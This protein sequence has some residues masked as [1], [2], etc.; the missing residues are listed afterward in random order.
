[1]KN[2]FVCSSCGNEFPKW[3][4]KCPACGEWN[5]LVETA[6]KRLSGNRKQ[7]TRNKVQEK[8]ILSLDSPEL[9]TGSVSRVTTGIA[10][11][12]RVLGQ[13]FVPGQVI[14]L[15]GEPGIGKSTLLLQIAGAL[16]KGASDQGLEASKTK[17]NRDNYVTPNSNLSPL[18]SVLYICGEESPSQVK[19]RADRLG[20]KGENISLLAETDVDSLLNLIESGKWKVESSKESKSFRREVGIP[21]EGSGQSSIL[22]FQ[23]LIIDSVQTLSTQDLISASGSVAQVKECAAR[24]INFAK[25]QN[26][27]TILVG[28]VNKEGEI[29]GPKVLE[30]MVDTVLYLEGERFGN[31]RLLRCIKNRFG[32]V[33]E[34]GVF[35]MAENGFREVRNPSAFFISESVKNSPGSVLSVVLEGTRPVL[36]EV[37]A[38]VSKSAFNYPRRAVSGFELNR[39]YFLCAVIEKFLKIS[40]PSNDVYVNVTSG[41]KIEEPAGDLALA[42]AIVSSFKGRPL[43]PKTLVFG[44][45]GLSG[46]VRQVSGQKKRFDEAKKLGFTNIISPLNVKT[47]AEAVRMALG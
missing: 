38:L 24:I 5:S 33:G 13:G 29:A 31:L 37:Q 9:V 17:K 8:K 22:N 10:E 35:Q 18:A 12:D 25:D 7:V 11:F 40:L 21:T 41:A 28:H 23:L 44:E 34:V 20:L 6:Q 15:A 30:H 14:L 19:I 43:K 39:L 36:L 45:V 26:L 4:G 46:E 1:M 16:S 47:V 32:D 3:Q 2:L 42:L 27:I